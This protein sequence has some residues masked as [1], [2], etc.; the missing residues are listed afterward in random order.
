MINQLF[1]GTPSSRR[2]VT[3]PSG[4]SIVAGQPLLIGKLPCV[5][6]DSYQSNTGGATCLFGGSFSLTVIGASDEASPPTGAAIKP[7]DK[8]YA[9]GTLDSTTNVTYGLTINADSS[10]TLF[11]Y[12]D[13]QQPTVASGTTNTQAAVALVNGF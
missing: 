12:L 5:A 4:A 2:F 9:V 10:K 7:G 11:G 6:L 1:N 8:V 3:M 13:P